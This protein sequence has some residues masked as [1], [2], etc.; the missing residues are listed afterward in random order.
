[1]M[2]KGKRML[3]LVILSLIAGLV[4]LTPFLRFSF[5]DQMKEALHFTDMQI[6]TIGAVYGVFN[7]ASYA[8]S[9][10]L[11]ERFDTKK[12]L[13]ISCLGMCIC[14]IWYSFYPGY[15]AMLVIHA[16]YGI[17]SV[18]TFWSPYLKAV[19]SLG[20]EQEQGTIFGI[21][22]GLRGLGQTAVA[23]LCLGVLG[24]FASS[25]LGF[26]MLLWVNVAAFAL[27]FLAVLFLVPGF[28]NPGEAEAEA[29]AGQKQGKGILYFLKNPSVWICIFVI[30]CGYT[31]WNTVNGY[32]GTYCTRILQ[33]PMELSSV[34]SIVRS[35]VIVFIAGVTGGILMDRFPSKGY[36]MM[37]AFA[38]T[39]ISGLGVIVTRNAIML[40][41]FITIILSYMVNVIKSTYWSILGD[42]GIPPE[43]TGMA[44]GIIS[45]IGLTPD[46]FVSPVISGFITWGESR[47]NVE[48]GF[49]LM[50]AW[51][52]IW[53][54]LGV[55]ASWFLKRKKAKTMAV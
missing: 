44:T 48:A 18:G 40:C 5:Y 28:G 14:T 35:Y 1:M 50:L 4:Y 26:R 42:G 7:V 55:L 19:R 37:T 10:F 27:L 12:L 22:E 33:I 11:A 2:N 3:V 20:S 38:L 32:I 46:I 29:G 8:P 31:L 34:L 36:G 17:F 49:N 43:E 47:G 23:F 41:V 30:M 52:V 53:S 15:P 39:C 54:V 24:M 45:L 9:G 6:G 21:S 13:L 16:L 25:A 51:L